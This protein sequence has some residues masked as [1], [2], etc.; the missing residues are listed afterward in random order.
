MLTGRIAMCG[1]NLFVSA[2]LV[3]A[4]DNSHL[5]GEHYNRKLAD[6]L[7]VQDVLLRRHCQMNLPV[8]P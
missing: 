4:R 2:E 5:W 3:D 6:G 1:E 7:A 8:R